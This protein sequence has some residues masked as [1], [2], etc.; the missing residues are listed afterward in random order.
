PHLELRNGAVGARHEHHL[1]VGLGAA[2]EHEGASARLDPYL[3]DRDAERLWLLRLGLNRGAA[4]GGFVRE[5]MPGCDPSDGCD[6]N[7]VTAP[8]RSTSRHTSPRSAARC[9]SAMKR[10]RTSASMS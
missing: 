6:D 1:P 9:S 8:S 4:L 10:A 5:E 3:D 2:G 7:T